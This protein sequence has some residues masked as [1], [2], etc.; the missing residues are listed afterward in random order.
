MRDRAYQAYTEEENIIVLGD[1][2]IE[3]RINNPLF[4]A[5]TST[6]LV[7]P[8]ALAH[9]RTTFGSVPKFYDQIAWFM[10]A[11]DLGFEGR[12][13][14]IDF[15]RAIFPELTRSQVSYRVS[16]HLPLWVEF[17]LDSSEESMARTLGVDPGMP[18]PLSTVPDNI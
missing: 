16:D 4:E 12:A 2:N 15:S 6:G 8:D 17:I 11:F 18:D 7:V 14:T 13:G 5:F 1:F 3:T 9:L 10:E